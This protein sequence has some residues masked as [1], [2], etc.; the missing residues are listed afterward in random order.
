MGCIEAS[1]NIQ[2]NLRMD[3]AAFLAWHQENEGRYELVGC[4]VIMMAGIS[5]AHIRIV[6]N[7]VATLRSQL[8]PEQW[9]ALGELGLDSGPETLRYPDVVVDRAGGADGDYIATAPVLLAEVLSPSTT[10]VDLGDKLAEY[11]EIPSV[12]TYVIFAQNEA[13]A[14]MW[15]RVAGQFTPKPQVITGI[16]AT[17]NVAAL[18]IELPMSEIYAGV[19]IAS[20]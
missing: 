9:E 10:A 3:K 6:Q 11:L 17:V 7:L 13:K 1:M 4:R 14:W 15:V 19:K 12:S 18:Q 2:P 8:D 20:P 16:E 5:R